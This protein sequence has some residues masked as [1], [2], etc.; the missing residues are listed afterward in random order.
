[1]TECTPTMTAMR[2]A[3]VYYSGARSSGYPGA[4]QRGKAEYARFIAQ[5]RRD[6]VLDALE[7]L[8]DQMDGEYGGENSDG[9]WAAQEV[10][11][12]YRTTI[13]PK[14]TP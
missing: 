2:N 1:M 9:I 5:V 4:M 13:A 14:E 12:D 11:R 8:Y 10:I 3:W 6:A 7:V